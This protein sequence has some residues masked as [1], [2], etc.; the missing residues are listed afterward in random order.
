VEAPTL[1]RTPEDS[2]LALPAMGESLG[3]EVSAQMGTPIPYPLRDAERKRDVELPARLDHRIAGLGREWVAAEVSDL[4]RA[5]RIQEH[6]HRDFVYS[7]DAGSSP[8]RDPL[9]NFLFVTRRGYCEYFASAM[10][11]LLRTQQIP[12]RVVTGFQSGYYND[13]SGSWVMRASDAHAWVEAW[14]DG[15]GWVTF[16]PTPPG[17]AQADGGWLESKLR[18]MGMYLD[19]ADTTWQ[20]WV[21]AYNPNQQAALAFGFWN[22]VWP[23]AQGETVYVW[24]AGRFPG[25]RYWLLFGLALGVIKL[26]SLVRWKRLWSQWDAR[27][28]MRKIRRGEG[29]ANDAS[30]LYERMLESMARRGFQKPAWFTPME[31][32]RNLPV[33]ERERIGSFTAAYN[34]VRF[35]GDP[36]GAA[37][38]AQMLEG[39]EGV[40]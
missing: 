29:T 36:G 35:G 28:R 34:E 8:V 33:G 6:L 27:Q 11:V 5:Q 19:A 20:Q 1:A 16:D 21:L 4:A 37:R 38:L 23:L 12:A 24:L 10:A 18:R 7:L 26:L 2:F 30:V 32:A 3:Y 17:A 14:I 39:M 25:L 13:V 22:K 15:R 40:G 9:A 31:F